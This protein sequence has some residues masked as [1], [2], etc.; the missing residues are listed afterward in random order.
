MWSDAPRSVG[1]VGTTNRMVVPMTVM[2][3]VSLVDSYSPIGADASGSIDALD[4]GAAWLG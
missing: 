2:V 3:R 1:S 4:T